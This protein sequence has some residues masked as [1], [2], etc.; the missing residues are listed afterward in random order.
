MFDVT[1]K[2]ISDFRSTVNE[3]SFVHFKYSNVNGK[4]LF[5]PIC[6]CMDWISVAIRSIENAHPLSDHIDVEVMQVFSLIS[7]IDLVVESITTLHTI[8]NGT[9]KRI[10]PFNGKKEIF[11]DNDFYDDDRYFTQLRACFGAHP[12]NLNDGGERRFASWPYK[13]I[14]RD[15]DLEVLLYSNIVDKPDV[16][17]GLRLPELKAYLVSRNNYIQELENTVKTQLEEYKSECI[18]AP[19][20]NENDTIKQLVILKNE[21]QKRLNLDF[22]DD[23]VRELLIL[24]KVSLCEPEVQDL[25]HRFKDRLKCY[26]NEIKEA[27]QNMD[28]E[29]NLASYKLLDAS[30]LYKIRSYELP[31]FFSW[32]NGEAHDPL[33]EHYFKRFNDISGSPIN[34]DIEESKEITILKLHLLDFHLSENQ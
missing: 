28:F 14:T 12:V 9:A 34:F 16:I 19:I 32:L 29:T 21:V 33:V 15:H 27:L 6:S 26:I 17:F 25:E 22:Y 8:I 5:S 23:A 2:Q 13:S 4:N 10:S 20:T 24:F 7:S 3:L 18:Q 31:K 30:N 11:S 1:D